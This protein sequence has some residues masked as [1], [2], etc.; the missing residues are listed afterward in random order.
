MAVEGGH[1]QVRPDIREPDSDLSEELSGLDAGEL[2]AIRLASALQCPVLMD[3]P[4]TAGGA[5][6]KLT[7]IGSA[8]ILLG[9][10]QRGLIPA[11]APILDQWRHSGY[12]LSMAVVQAVLGRAGEA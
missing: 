4:W 6:E 10:K 7:V 1:V 11:V 12:F 8:G 5:S 3:E 2:A 9:A